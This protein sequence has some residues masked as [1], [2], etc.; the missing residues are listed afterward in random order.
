MSTALITRAAQTGLLLLL[1]SATGCSLK[2]LAVN[3]V[4]NALASSGTTFASDDDPELVKAAV[5]FSLKL[6]ESLLAESP[7]HA[8][9]LRATASG[10]TQY[11]YAFVQQEADEREDQNFAAAE[12]LRARAR[13]LYVRARDYGLRA[14]EVAHPGFGQDLRQAPVQAVAACRTP[15]VPALYWTAVAWGATIA[16]SKDDPLTIVEI[17]QMEA[18]IDR[19]LALEEDWNQGAIHAFLINYEGSRSGAPTDAEARARAHF[20]RAVELSEARLAGPFVS[21]AEAVSVQNQALEEF[22]ALLA[23]ALAINP[24]AFPEHRLEN[25]IMQRRA[26]WLLAH[27]EDLFVV[28]LPAPPR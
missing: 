23:Q 24:D 28:G 12:A 5:P 15:D 7:E 10:F 18:L 21:L 3:Q 25:L 26:A 22:E 2:R 11:A 13:R 16:L 20:V 19:A 8:A 9:L 17:P 14:L 4:G 6:M 1:V 27:K